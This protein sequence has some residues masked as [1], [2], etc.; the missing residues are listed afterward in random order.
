MTFDTGEI[1]NFEIFRVLEL[2]NFLKALNALHKTKQ[3]I[4]ININD[5]NNQFVRNN[6]KN[7]TVSPYHGRASFSGHLKK[8]TEGILKSGFEKRFATLT[9]IGLIIMDQPNGKTLEVIN[10]MFATW[11]IYNGGDGDYCFCLYIGKNKHIFSSDTLFLRNRWITEFEKWIKKIKED[12][13][14]S[15]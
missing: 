1:I 13:T 5:Y 7:F 8:W 4:D 12:E 6:P 2:M 11:N 9:E 3:E 15:V 10:L 14:I